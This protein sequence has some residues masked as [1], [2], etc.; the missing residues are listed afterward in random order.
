M[1]FGARRPRCEVT[2]ERHGRQDGLRGL[3]TLMLCGGD[4]GLF[5]CLYI[6]ITNN[7]KDRQGNCPQVQELVGQF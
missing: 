1:G 4:H 6:V 5:Y 3:G 7:K 2:A